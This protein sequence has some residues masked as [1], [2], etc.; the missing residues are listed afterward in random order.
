MGS[1]HHSVVSFYRRTSVRSSSS[2]RSPA[3][4]SSD[5]RECVTLVV[6]QLPIGFGNCSTSAPYSIQYA[7]LID[8]YPGHLHL[9]RYA[10][11]PL[12]VETKD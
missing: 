9:L 10:I 5:E 8:L 7:S 2:R 11:R 1:S 3:A 12:S 4:T 6:S